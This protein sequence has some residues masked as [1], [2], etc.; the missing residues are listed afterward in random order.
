MSYNAEYQR[1][2]KVDRANGIK[3]IIDAEQTHLHIAGLLGAGWSM[4]SIAGEAGVSVQVISKIMKGQPQVRRDISEAII[5]VTGDRVARRT[6]GRGQPFIPRVGTVRRLQA[7]LYMGWTW[8]ILW[9]RYEIRPAFLHQQGRWVTVDV[10]DR[11][12]RA[13]DELGGSLG[14]SERTRRRAR[15]SGY[16]GPMHWDDADIDAEPD[17]GSVTEH[18]S[19]DLDEV[20]IE[21]RLLGDRSV[22]LTGPEQIELVRRWRL[23]GESDNECER[24][25]GINY[26]R[27]DAFAAEGLAS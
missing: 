9:E 19:P 26:V 23:T 18:W 24:R 8:A 12:C 17:A 27:V 25:T 4:R 5:G 22:S 3:R 21:R 10:H 13:F 16:A 6:D 15:R 1:Q 11:V 20:A 7:L 14:P 2:W